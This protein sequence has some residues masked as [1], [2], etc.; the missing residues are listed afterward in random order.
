[1]NFLGKQLKFNGFDLLHKGDLKIWEGIGSEPDENGM[2]TVISYKRGDGRLFLNIRFI[3]KVNGAYQNYVV[4]NYGRD[5]VTIESE[6]TYSIST[7][8]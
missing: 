6:N 7:V 3:D 1:M 2:D 5:G 4:T 8:Q